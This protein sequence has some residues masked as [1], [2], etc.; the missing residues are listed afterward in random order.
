MQHELQVGA[1]RTEDLLHLVVLVLVYN[2]VGLAFCRVAGN[3]HV[4]DDRQFREPCHILVAF[5]LVA[6]EL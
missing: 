3:G 5:D 4:G 1:Q 2:D 6:E